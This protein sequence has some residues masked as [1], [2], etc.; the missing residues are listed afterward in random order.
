MEKETITIPKKLYEQMKEE[1]G[2]IRDEE[3]ME[4]L[5]ESERAKEEGIEPWELKY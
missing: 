1:L 4:D 3:L 2:I 5:K